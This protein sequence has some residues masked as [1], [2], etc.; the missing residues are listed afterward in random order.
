MFRQIG[1]IGRFDPQ[2][3]LINLV[4][5]L[6][7]LAAAT[8]FVDAMMVYVLPQKKVYSE[9]KVQEVEVSGLIQD[10]SLSESL[11]SKGNEGA[12]SSY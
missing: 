1:E 7:L 8:T 6:G 9:A 2:T 12:G 3:C 11:V 4:T 5:A 10:G